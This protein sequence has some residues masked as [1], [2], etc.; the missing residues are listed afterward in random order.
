MPL[1]PQLR[2]AYERAVYVVFGSP[3]V[4]FRIGEPDAVLDA[5]MQMAHAECAAFVSSANARGV[6]T[7]E[8]ERRL[9]QFLLRAGLDELEDGARYRIDQGEGRDPEGKWSAEPS[10]LIVGIPRAEAEALGRTL[11]QNAIVWIEKG[12]APELVILV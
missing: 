1:D 3:N 7:P 8:N 11:E 9:A 4:E 2:A 6:R 10:V 5:M 12:K